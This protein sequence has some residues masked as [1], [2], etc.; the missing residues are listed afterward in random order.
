M[1][2]ILFVEDDP[3]IGESTQILLQHE[4]YAVDWVRSGL[5]AMDALARHTYQLVLLDLGLPEL[6][7]MEVLRRIRNDSQIGVLIITA[8][9]SLKDRVRGLNQGADDYLVKPYEFEELI[10]RIH[11]LLRRSSPAV[12]QDCYQIAGIRLYPATHRIFKQQQEIELSNKE[13][14]IL[15]PM[16]MHPGQIFSKSHLEQKLYDWQSDVS[17]NTIEVYIHHLR[18]KLGKDFIRTIRGIGYCIDQPSD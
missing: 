14:A 13:W 12:V 9:D 10:A 4:G 18:Q 17:S 7:G 2:K 6:E 8:R 15:E 11:A 1:I 5:A 16:M 3:M